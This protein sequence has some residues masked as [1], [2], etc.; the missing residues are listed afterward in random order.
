MSKKRHDA[1]TGTQP[2]ETTAALLRLLDHVQQTWRVY[3]AETPKGP[4]DGSDAAADNAVPLGHLPFT[5]AS[6]TWA[7]AAEHLLVYRLLIE[8]GTQP[9]AG[10]A[11]LLRGALEGA[12]VTRWLLDP[13]ASPGERISRAAA[14]QSEDHRQRDRFER[15]IGIKDGQFTPPAKSGAERLAQHEADI[16]RHGITKIPWPGF[17]ALIAAHA[18]VRGRTT[19]GDGRW[20]YQALSAIAHHLPWSIV[21]SERTDVSDIPGVEGSLGTTVAASDQIV[22]MFTRQTVSTV[23]IGLDELLTYIGRRPGDSG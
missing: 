7:A 20:L 16:D 8:T 21:F 5:F 3:Q 19:E 12:A 23:V 9:M 2:A 18:I 14:L 1:R 17:G 22:L 6:Q 11:T 15:G 10:H 13:T 4:A